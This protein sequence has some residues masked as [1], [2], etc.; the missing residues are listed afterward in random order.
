MSTAVFPVPFA[1]RYNPGELSPC[2]ALEASHF[3]RLIAHESSSH[4]AL[5]G[6]CMPFENLRLHVVLKQHAGP[7]PD[8]NR[9][10]GHLHE[11]THHHVMK[12]LGQQ[13]LRPRPQS[14]IMILGGVE[15]IGGKQIPGQIPV[16]SPIRPAHLLPG[17]RFQ[18]DA[19]TDHLET[20][21]ILPRLL[22]AQKCHIMPAGQVPHDIQGAHQPPPIG[23]K[24]QPFAQKQN[25]HQR[26][27]GS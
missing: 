8:P 20:I 21:L 22:V 10:S 4:P 27:K 26:F 6:L 9:I 13:L 14:G 25:L 23:R 18:T 7:V 24:E 1:H 17:E 19:Q 12:R 5:V 15:W 11:I 2:P 16:E 3:R